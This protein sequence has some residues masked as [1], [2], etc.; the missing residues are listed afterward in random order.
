MLVFDRPRRGSSHRL[1]AEMAEPRL[2]VE[3]ARLAV[4]A[5][6]HSGAVACRF[7][8]ESWCLCGPSLCWVLA[9][10]T[11]LMSRTA[12]ARPSWMAELARRVLWDC[13]PLY[14]SKTW[15]D[16]RQGVVISYSIVVVQGLVVLMNSCTVTITGRRDLHKV[17]ASAS[18]DDGQLM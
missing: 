4:V 16:I 5:R 6:L 11:V 13:A 18:Y 1:Q 7:L 3:E 15:K 8:M 10:V 14:I 17:S 9:I 2:A 12:L